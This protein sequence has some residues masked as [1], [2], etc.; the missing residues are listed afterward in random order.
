[1]GAKSCSLREECRVGGENKKPGAKKNG[2]VS[3]K[4][5]GNNWLKKR[6]GGVIVA[7]GESAEDKR[8][9]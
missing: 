7:G 9:R 4:T 2:G 1:M 5:G 8:W 3:L 6:N